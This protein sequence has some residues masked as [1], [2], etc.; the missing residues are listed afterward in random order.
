MDEGAI[1]DIV[2]IVGMAIGLTFAM[3]L[4]GVLTWAGPP[5]KWT[6]V[7][8]IVFGLLGLPMFAP[9]FV[10]LVVFAVANLVVMARRAQPV[11][12]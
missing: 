11:T 12:T 6:A 4:F 9:W 8:L 2:Y 3:I 5:P 1:G 7:V 10:G